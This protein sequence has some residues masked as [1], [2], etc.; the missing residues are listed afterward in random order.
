MIGILEDGLPSRG[1]D[2]INHLELSR[3]LARHGAEIDTAHPEHNSPFLRGVYDGSFAFV[4]GDP[5]KPNMAAGRAIQGAIRC[6]FHYNESVLFRMQAGMG[7]AVI[8]PLYEVLEQRDVKFRFF[9]A[10]KELVPSAG[11]RCG[12]STSRWCRRS[13]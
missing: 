3:W 6:L 8:A 13:R 2:T 12:S 9:H 1:F 11:R 5:L 4:D 7:D 10:V